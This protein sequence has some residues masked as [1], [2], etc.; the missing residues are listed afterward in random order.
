MA[1]N[2][3]VKAV[4]QSSGQLLGNVTTPKAYKGWIRVHS[5]SWGMD[6]PTDAASGLPTGHQAHRR[7]TI[8]LADAP[9][10]ALLARSEATN[11]NLTSVTLA[12]DAPGASGTGKT[13]RALTIK[14]TNAHV[15]SFSVNGSDPDAAPHQQ[16]TL[17][18]QKIDYTAGANTFLDDWEARV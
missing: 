3:F 8:V 6:T 9:A 11:E 16:V 18:Y 1:L 13:V 14:L 5:F 12:V 7:L 15:T 10:S 17:A 2:M 4:G